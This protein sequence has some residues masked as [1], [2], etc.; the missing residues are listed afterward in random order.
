MSDT[1]PAP[2]GASGPRI[3]GFGPMPG[4]VSPAVQGVAGFTEA[5]ADCKENR[6]ETRLSRISVRG[7]IALVVFSTL[8]YRHRR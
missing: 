6:Q 1:A 2:A 3:P 4:G 5:A 7:T 8:I